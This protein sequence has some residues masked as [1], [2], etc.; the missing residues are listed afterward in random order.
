MRR[1][2]L[3][4]TFWISANQ[5]GGEALV[6]LRNVVLARLIGPAEMGMALTLALTLRLL[7]MLSDL[8][9]DRLIIQ[10]PD[11]NDPR[12]QANAQAVLLIRGIISGSLMAMLAVPA[13]HLFGQPRG[14]WAFASLG[15]VPIARGLMHL[16]YKRVQREMV[17]RPALA[18]E[19]PAGLLATASAIPLGWLLRDY[20][21]VVWV[22]LIQAAA[23]IVTSHLTAKRRYVLRLDSALIRRFLHFGWPLL[24]NGL[25]LF[26]VLQGDRLIVA[27]SC[28]AADLGR[29]AL[30][31]QLSMIPS[32]LIARIASSA[33]LP[34][35]AKVQHDAVE[36]TRRY[37]NV[38]ISLSLVA[39]AY[40]V[41]FSSGGNWVIGLLFG[42]SFQVSRA[43]I[44]WLATAQAVRVVR[45]MS[46]IAAMAR[47]DSRLPLLANLFRLT[48]IAGAAAAAYGRLP[49]EFI[50]AA[51]CVG[52]FI[53]GV[54]A[55]AYLKRRHDLP[56]SVSLWGFVLIGCSSGLGWSMAL[57]ANRPGFVGAAVC[58]V[59]AVGLLTA[60]HKGLTG[61][62]AVC[63]A[64]G[65]AR[66][67]PTIELPKPEAR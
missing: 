62:R 46:S 61:F 28:S 63:A 37:V 2:I 27:L 44:A 57:W 14:A 45:T 25:I 32:L 49:L 20:S 18:V 64:P 10:A 50:A 29:F 51:G 31:F 40:L 41:A 12:F 55:T 15:L 59:A 8:S 26:G 9:T 11:G 5:F 16:D 21:A 42:E 17:F 66:I 30:A 39:A 3:K 19:L 65:R 34:W 33:A 53:A 47:A 36:F 7:E 58:C 6:L 22:S 1:R 48:G 67:F 35:M 60:L 56:M 24:L 43:L 52:E 13:A 4:A 38:N 54:A 23:L